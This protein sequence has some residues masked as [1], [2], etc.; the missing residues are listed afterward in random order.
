MKPERDKQQRREGALPGKENNRT[1]ERLTLIEPLQEGT[2]HRFPTVP[3]DEESEELVV[4]L[5]AVHGFLVFHTF[6]GDE[7]VDDLWVGHGTVAFELLADDVAEVG[8]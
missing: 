6:F 4:H 1:N 5:P 8:W 7:D 2:V 3:V